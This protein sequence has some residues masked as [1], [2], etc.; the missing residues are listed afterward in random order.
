MT[1]NNVRDSLNFSG[2]IVSGEVSLSE[3]KLISI[4]A[5]EHYN[6][7][8]ICIAD[9][10]NIAVAEIHCNW[11]DYQNKVIL[12]AEI[13]KRWNAYREMQAEIDALKAEVKRLKS[14]KFPVMLRKM[15]SGGE[16][17]AWLDEATQESTNDN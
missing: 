10:V 4:P 2:D 5:K 16:V 3:A 6:S 8:D 15:W 1:M 7:V 13:E 12:G 17:Q 11:L 14:L 9:T